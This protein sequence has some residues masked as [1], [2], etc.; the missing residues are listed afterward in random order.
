[1]N[2]RLSVSLLFGV[3]LSLP[4]TG[5]GQQ[6]DSTIARQIVI[7]GPSFWMKDTTETSRTA[8]SAVSVRGLSIPERA[9]RI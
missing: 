7:N 5:S 9:V 2:R 1:M 6:T 4:L 8:N 3:L